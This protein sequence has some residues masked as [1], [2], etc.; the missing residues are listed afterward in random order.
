ME[1]NNR[2]SYRNFHSSL[3]L[4]PFTAIV[5]ETDL[6]ILADMDLSSYALNSIIQYRSQIEDYIVHD[7]VFIQSFLP[8][9][10]DPK[11]PP[12]VREMMHVSRNAGVGP[13]ASVAGVISD[14]VG[15]D[16]LSE[17]RNVVVEN[18]GDIFIKFESGSMR[19]GLFA[20]ES[21]ISMKF[22]LLINAE[23]TP[24]GICTSSGTVGPS[25]SLG[26]ADAVCVKS[27]KASLSD[28]AATAI[29]NMVKEESDI[30]KAI[31]FGSKIEG[32]LGIVI[33]IG[34]K[35]GAWGQIEFS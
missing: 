20:G 25:I 30:E 35:M 15:L 31:E 5:K 26:K 23:D 28:A 29:G 10:D 19:V 21:P 34:T 4:V 17:S 8:V 24:L 14:F 6:F 33:I 9:I 27:G 7:P 22:S 12:I 11:A 1:Y 16:L 2:S 18:G 3:N 32:V 13:M